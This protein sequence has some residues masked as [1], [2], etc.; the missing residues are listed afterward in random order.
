[1]NGSG[2]YIVGCAGLVLTENEAAFYRDADPF[3][4]ILFARNIE[5]SEQVRRLTFDLRASVGWNAPVLIDQ[6]GGRVQRMHAPHW[7]EW[8]PP[9]DLISG[10]RPDAGTRALTIRMQIIASELRDVGIDVNC[11]PL[12]DIATDDTH[13]FLR[14]RTYGTTA[15]Q[16]AQNARAVADGLLAGGVLPVIKHI[17]GHGRAQQDSHLEPPVVDQPKPVLDVTDFAPFKTLNDIG[18]G[19][20]GHLVYPQIDPGRPAT[21][22]PVLMTIIRDE[23]GF[24]G[25]LMTDDIS[26]EALDGTVADRSV[27]A[28]R[29]GCDVALHCNGDLAEMMA[30]ATAT[31]TMSAISQSRAEAALAQR[32]DP[33]NVDIPALDAE[34][35]SLLNAGAHAE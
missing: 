13:P 25:L 27:A 8:T 31:G 24:Q 4:F 32:S 21:L 9:M 7:R 5:N 35:G 14:N 33:V 16:V 18:M 19:M 10:L 17:P 29:A 3:G 11:A 6:E 1:M 26:M 20:T 12:A 34:L 2:A 28:I 30:I 22:S 15:A 23:I